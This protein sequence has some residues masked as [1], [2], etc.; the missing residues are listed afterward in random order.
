[1]DTAHLEP[2]S[3]NGES[4]QVFLLGLGSGMGSGKSVGQLHARRKA[5]TSFLFFKSGAS[6]PNR[7]C[8]QRQCSVRKCLEH[9]EPPT[10][11]N[12]VRTV[13]IPTPIPPARQSVYERKKKPSSRASSHLRTRVE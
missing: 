12:P 10:V 3:S 9:D 6:L 5:S 1:M 7:P 2:V 13:E 8:K 4:S 11:V